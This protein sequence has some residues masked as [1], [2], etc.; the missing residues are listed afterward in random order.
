MAY[1]METDSN[2]SIIFRKER[3]KKKKFTKKYK[4]VQKIK[5]NSKKKNR[6]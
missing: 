4:N 2:N 5:K 3:T 6:K 1:L